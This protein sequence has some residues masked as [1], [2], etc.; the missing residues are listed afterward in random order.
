[1]TIRILHEPGV[2]EWPCGAT[3][4]L[5]DRRAQRLIH[6]GYAEPV[7]DVVAVK[8]KKKEKG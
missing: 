3:V 1:M 6:R 7:P 8:A 2:G 4:E 5:E